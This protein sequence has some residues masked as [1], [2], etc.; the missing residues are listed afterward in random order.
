MD[1]KEYSFIGAAEFGFWKVESVGF[2]KYA[3]EEPAFLLLNAD[4]ISEAIS[5][6]YFGKVLMLYP[7]RTLKETLN[8]DICIKRFDNL[9][10]I[11]NASTF[12]LIF[13]Q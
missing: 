5:R 6:I 10:Y 9:S 13:K 4:E 11:F 1:E 2:Q 12:F 7:Y 8:L 3:L